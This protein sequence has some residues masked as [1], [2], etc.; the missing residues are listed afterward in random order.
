MPSFLSRL[1]LRAS[2]RI[3][4]TARGSD[5]PAGTDPD[6][7]APGAPGARE[8]GVMR[9]RLRHV[10]RTREALLL[11][12]GAVTFELHRAGRTDPDLLARK[13]TEIDAADRE[14]RALSQALRTGGRPEVGPLAPHH[15][16][17][18]REPAAREPAPAEPE[19]HDDLDRTVVGG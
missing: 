7:A 6:A 13:A 12:L 8:R 10:T 5:P 3:D 18:G 11:E 4:R 16:E 15:T 9:R 19:P 2:D 17:D 1:R 14:A